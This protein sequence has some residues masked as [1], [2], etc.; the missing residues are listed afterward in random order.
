MSNR[1]HRRQ[2]RAL[3]AKRHRAAVLQAK[4]RSTDRLDGLRGMWGYKI[5]ADQD[6][7]ERC[8]PQCFRAYSDYEVRATAPC[9][10]CRTEVELSS[11][12]CLSQTEA[13]YSDTMCRLGDGQL[14]R[15]E[16][17]MCER[18]V[19]WRMAELTDAAMRLID[20]QD[21]LRRTG[22]QSGVAAKV[23]ELRVNIDRAR[24]ALH[25]AN[26]ETIDWESLCD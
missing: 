21:E 7:E 3:I 10:L 14:E 11:L 1:D 24:D 12:G 2:R 15:Y 23:K 16:L 25:L 5:T 18:K 8:C 17:E 13:E 6:I 20:F 26:A 4:I 19:D 22:P 9:L